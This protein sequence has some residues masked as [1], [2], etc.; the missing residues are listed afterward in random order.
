MNVNY[1]EKSFA[2]EN[3]YYCSIIINMIRHS[4]VS[5]DQLKQNIQVLFN[6]GATLSGVDSHG[7]DSLMYAIM[8][9]DLELVNFLLENINKG[10]IR[11]LTD[12][13]GKNA[14]HYVVTPS[15]FGSFENISILKALLSIN[16]YFDLNQRDKLGK[17]PLDYAL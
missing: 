1:R 7:R 15:K 17:T 14:I 9:N 2:D 6:N 4:S 12:K 8:N 13:E 10:L 3:D 16:N 11:N 5:F